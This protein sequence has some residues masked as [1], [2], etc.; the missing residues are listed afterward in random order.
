MSRCR[1]TEIA[2]RGCGEYRRARLVFAVALKLT[3]KEC[4]SLRHLCNAGLYLGNVFSYYRPTSSGLA[5]RC[6]WSELLFS[7]GR[8]EYPALSVCRY[9][10]IRKDAKEVTHFLL[11]VLFTRCRN[12]E[13]ISSSPKYRVRRT[14][15]SP[16]TWWYDYT[17]SY[18][19]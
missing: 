3:F 14:H 9:Q 12:L 16:S 8:A 6:T 11:I 10:Q 2:L 13:R 7:T 15:D 17:P 5:S 19:L 4:C 18:D 1:S